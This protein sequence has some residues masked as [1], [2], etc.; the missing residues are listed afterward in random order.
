MHSS[1]WQGCVDRFQKAGFNV[2]APAWPGLEE[3]S[4]NDIRADASAL[5]G[6]TIKAIRDY[7]ENIIRKLD[8]PPII[9]GHSFGGLLPQMLLSRIIAIDA[10]Q[11][12]GVLVLPLSTFKSGIPVLGN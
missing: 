9:M 2:L 5:R 7:Y 6:L 3:R 11:P 8:T 1:S 10:T 12:S 4:V